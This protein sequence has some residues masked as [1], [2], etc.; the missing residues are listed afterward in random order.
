VQ[1]PQRRGVV[2]NVLQHVEADHGVE[3]LGAE[4]GIDGGQPQLRDRDLRSGREPLAQ[5]AEVVRLAV[6]E[7]DALAVHQES[8]HVADPGA[9]LEDPSPHPGA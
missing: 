5:A 7:H 2:V 6:G 3:A 4:A 9:D 1:R 8:R